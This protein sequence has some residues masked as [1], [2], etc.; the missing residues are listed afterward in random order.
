M[1][2][3][4]LICTI[5]AALSLIT[6]T[7]IAAQESLSGSVTYVVAGALLD[8]ES[9]RTLE[10]QAIIIVGERIIATPSPESTFSL[11]TASVIQKKLPWLVGRTVAI[12]LHGRSLKPIASERQSLA[13]R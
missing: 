8:V 11:K 1:R 13:L 2:T 9:G 6:A 10:N 5:T 7:T 3:Q 4:N 12:C